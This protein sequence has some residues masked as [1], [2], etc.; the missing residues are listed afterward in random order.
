MRDCRLYVRDILEAMVAVQIL[1]GG[2]DYDDFICDDRTSSAVFRKLV[3][4]GEAAKSIPDSVR[5]Q[6][7][8]IPW[9][10]LIELGDEF[11][12]RYY[13]VNSKLVWDTVKDLTPSVQSVIEEILEGWSNYEL[14][15]I[16]S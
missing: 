6:Y 4:F 7:S 15:Y 13:D 16:Q 9:Q 3:V 10:Q 12:D 8:H 1:V 11:L 2:M 5:E 14:S